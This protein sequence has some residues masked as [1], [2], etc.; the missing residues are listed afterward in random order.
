[1]LRKR[2]AQTAFA[3]VFSLLLSSC[4]PV[5][6]PSA[7]IAYESCEQVRSDFASGVAAE[8]ADIDDLVIRPVT[9]Q[10]GYQAARSLDTDG[11]GVACEYPNPAKAEGQAEPG[12]A[13]HASTFFNF[14]FDPEGSLERS[15]NVGTPW[16][17]KS[18]DGTS[19]STIR[20]SAYE[21]IRSLSAGD[22]KPLVN[23]VVGDDV[24]AD[25]LRAY[26]LQTAD[27]LSRM[28]FPEL[29]VPLDLLVFTEKDFDLVESYWGR[30]WS[31][32][33]VLRR[34]AADLQGYESARG[35]NWSVGGMSEVRE[36]R[37][38]SY[39]SVG[40][41]FYM[42]SQH[43]QETSLLGDHVAH[44]LFHAWQWSATGLPQKIAS[45]ERFDI[46]D[47][48]PC[49]AI[50]GAAAT[51]GNAILMPYADWFGDGADVVVRRVA[52]QDGLTTVTDEQVIE[53]LVKGESWSSCSEAYA[54]GMLA[55]EW[56]IGEHGVEKF[57]EIYRNA[58]DR[59]PFSQN[60]QGLYGFNKD[61]FYRMVA[62]YV[63]EEFNRA[64]EKQQY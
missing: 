21:S 54:I 35:A 12:L 16:G 53:L 3:A 19:V 37:D 27:F 46:A 57:L 43:S 50:E 34:H 44:E 61:E 47:F 13:V 42:S 56:L 63:A 7:E 24:P 60:L 45:R 10:D 1:M 14:R 59:V 30:M 25:M 8:S 15:G 23:W 28:P 18:F 55:Y 52:N 48:V 62:P 11:D 32:E 4:V 9:S 31:G 41:D 26:E 38:G 2:A 49:H 33:S 58:G 17:K 40:V 5:S 20:S 29:Q 6:D 51:F 39:P 22:N 64:Q 36:P